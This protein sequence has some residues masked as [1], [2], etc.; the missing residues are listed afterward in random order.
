M[1]LASRACSW[2]LPWRAAACVAAA[3]GPPRVAWRIRDTLPCRLL[4][5]YRR[6]RHCHV[7]YRLSRYG[8]FAPG[9]HVLSTCSKVSH[10]STM[11]PFRVHARTLAMRRNTSALS[12]VT[13]IA[14][15]LSICVETRAHA[16]ARNMCACVSRLSTSLRT[17][18]SRVWRWYHRGHG[19]SVSPVSGLGLRG[20]GSRG[21]RVSRDK[22]SRVLAGLGL[23][24]SRVSPVLGLPGSQSPRF[25]RLAGLGSRLSRLSRLSRGSFV[26]IVSRV[27]GL[28]LSGSNRLAGSHGTRDDSARPVLTSRGL[29]CLT[30]R[31]LAGLAVSRC[32]SR[33][34]RLLLC[35]GFLTP[36]PRAVARVDR[37]AAA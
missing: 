35:A 6:T 32:R 16:H 34:A 4:V 13:G 36:C 23:P 26:S 5:P 25:F 12:I 17:P 27:S 1:P 28:T 11:S 8:R 21:S 2:S 20:L 14:S 37:L 3:L 7:T 31:W 29:A 18:E 19:V 24:V 9:S 33:T 30:S 22:R 15:I 10:N